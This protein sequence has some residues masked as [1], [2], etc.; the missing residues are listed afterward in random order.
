[1]KMRLAS[2]GGA[3]LL[4]MAALC[5]AQSRPA[6]KPSSGNPQKNP[7]E[8]QIEKKEQSQRALGV[9]PQ[10]AVTSRQNAPPLSHAEKFHLFA[11]S[12]F[13]P[14][15]LGIV[16][17]QAALSQGENEFPAYGQ[18]AEGYAK[19]YGASLTDEVS[20]GF[21][22]NYLYPVLLK[23]D[24]RYF[25]LGEGSM[26]H[27]VFYSLK[28]EFVCHTDSGGRSFGWSNTLGAFSSGGL[29]NLYYPQADRG[30]GLT[31]SRGGIA[32][33]YGSVGGLLDEFWPDINKKIHH[34]HGENGKG[35]SPAGGPK[36]P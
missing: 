9:L 6:P 13:D 4:L 14:V 35:P 7:D 21:L 11:K 31:M 2:V 19:R 28:Q 15:E 36:S 22:S 12:A 18:G 29:S 10:F 1:M 16:G 8:K 27:R 17:V 20:S 25:R 3:C 5:G 26:R 23:E 30:F 33:L 32:L 24:P 34:R